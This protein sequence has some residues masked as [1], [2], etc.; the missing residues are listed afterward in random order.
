MGKWKVVKTEHGT[1][2]SLF[3]TTTKMSSLSASVS[4][5]A[6]A[7]GGGCSP[8]LAG[9]TIDSIILALKTATPEQ[10]AEIL[11][12]LNRGMALYTASVEPPVK[13]A[14]AAVGRPRKAAAVAAAPLPE[15]ADGAPDAAAYRMSA[16]SIDTDK[17]V[18]RVM[19][20]TDASKDK[21]WKPAVYRE[22]QCGGSLVEGSDLCATCQKRFEAFT[23]SGKPKNWNGRI[24]EEPPSW[25]HMLGTA[26]ASKCKWD[27]DGASAA[28]SVASS[29]DLKASAAMEKKAAAAEKKAAAEAKKAEAA[30]KKAAAAEAKKA[31][32]AEKPKKEKAEKPKKE[33]ES[34]KEKGGAAAAA[35]AEEAPAKADTAA[36]AADAE[37]E[38][39]L[40]DGS[41]YSVKNGNVYEYDNLT[42]QTGDFVGRL[43]EEGAI[44][45]DAEE[46]ADSDSADEE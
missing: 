26:W 37:A 32:A 35:A 38:L 42:E 3:A 36:A 31:A 1:K 2:L 43:T 30:A 44:D 22:F 34:K 27:P 7:G 11:T 16:E 14:S 25:T 5:A 33:K 39:K 28:S 6:A 20:E 17:C 8:S 10:A 46:V 15:A 4:S 24:T 23:E 40:I 41:W 18:A 21:R 13:K 9:V 45:G 19:N 12:A 29:A